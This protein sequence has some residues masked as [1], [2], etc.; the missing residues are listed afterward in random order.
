MAT[1]MSRL[2]FDTGICHPVNNCSQ[3][4]FREH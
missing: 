2:D 3:L 4:I 1:L